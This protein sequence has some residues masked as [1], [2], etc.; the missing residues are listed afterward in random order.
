MKICILICGLKRCIDLVINNIE[1]I[2]IDHEINIITS[3]NNEIEDK[4][5]I[6]NKNIIKKIFIND[7]HNNDFRNSL[8]YSNKLIHGLKI[9]ENKYDL[10]IIVRTDLIIKNINLNDIQDNK[11]YFSKKNMNQFTKNVLNKVNDNI[12]LTK[13]YNLFL[14]L[15]NLYEFT[16]NNNNYL[17]IV[18]YDYLKKY[19]INYD[20]IDIEYKLILSKCNV[21]AIAGDS[22]SGKSTLLKVLSNKPE[23]NI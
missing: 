6:N 7:I 9:A 18:L 23:L 10:Y 4:D 2:F 11:L 12:I 22:G 16:I 14:K 3:L 20:L 5:I 17:D 19:D 21:I 15:I 1:E 13:D 8:N